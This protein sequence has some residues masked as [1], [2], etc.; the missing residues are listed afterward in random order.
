M[1]LRLN[2]TST[3][4][5]NKVLYVILIFVYIYTATSKILDMKTTMGSMNNQ[6]FDNR[7]TPALIAF[8]LIAEYATSFLLLFDKTRRIGY[9]TSLGM[10]ILFT[11]YVGLVLGNYYDRVPCSCGGIINT[12]SWTQH[13]VLNL[14]LI[15]M[16]ILG[17]MITKKQKHP[18]EGPVYNKWMGSPT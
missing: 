14:M 13:L 3:R 6:P 15:V 5:L 7:F 17:L 4:N 10:M 1:A 2:T 9:W 12:L 11:G 18:P 8:V 16:S